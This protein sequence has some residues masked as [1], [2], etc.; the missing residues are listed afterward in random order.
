MFNV[1]ITVIGG[2]FCKIEQI[3]VVKQ[4]HPTML[5]DGLLDSSKYPQR[6]ELYSARYKAQL[7]WL[8]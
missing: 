8:N 4:L 1:K 5:E 2:E 6:H 7:G 3:D